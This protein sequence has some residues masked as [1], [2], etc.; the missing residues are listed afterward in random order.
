MPRNLLE[1][2]LCMAWPPLPPTARQPPRSHLIITEEK[3]SSAPHVQTLWPINSRFCR[4][5]ALK[6]LYVQLIFAAIRHLEQP[7][8]CITVFCTFLAIKTEPSQLKPSGFDRWIQHVE[9]HQQLIFCQNWPPNGP[10]IA[11]CAYDPST[12]HNSQTAWTT[13]SSF[14]DN[15]LTTRRYLQNKI[16]LVLSL[17]LRRRRPLPVC[18]SQR[19]RDK[20]EMP[21]T[22]GFVHCNLQPLFYILAKPWPD[23]HYKQFWPI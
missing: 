21:A 18:A 1:K 9:V 13:A 22:S 16:W 10:S 5:T 3:S 19:L 15:T 7:V 6:D 2:I 12:G 4:K 20:P 17:T 14:G 8:N 11:D 23:C